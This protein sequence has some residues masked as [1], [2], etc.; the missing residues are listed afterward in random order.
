MFGYMPPEFNFFVWE[1]GVF[2]GIGILNLV[3]GGLSG[4]S[5][6]WSHHVRVNSLKDY[7]AAEIAGATALQADIQR[8]WN[9][10]A[11]QEITTFFAV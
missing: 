1:I 8:E 11:I 5:H 7:T 10:Y 4:L 2:W 3:Y 9:A 6:Y